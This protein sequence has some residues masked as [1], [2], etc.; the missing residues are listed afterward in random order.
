M[1]DDELEEGLRLVEVLGFGG[2]GDGLGEDFVNLA[3]VAEEDGFGALEFVGFNVVF[4]GLVVFNHLAGDRLGF[5]VFAAEIGVAEFE[6]VEG[7]VDEFGAGFGVFELVEQGD[8]VVELHALVLEA[9]HELRFQQIDLLAEDD[10][11]VFQNGFDERDDVEGVVFGLI[12][13]LGDG[14]EQVEAEGVVDGEVFGQRDI[15]GDFLRAAAFG[16]RDDVE[17]FRADEAAEEF[18]G[19]FFEELL[20]GGRLV[21]V[22]DD[23]FQRGAAVLGGAGEDVEQGV[24]IDGEAGDERFGRGG[25]EFGEGLFVPVHVAFFRGFAFFEGLLFVSSGFGGEAEVFDDVL[26]GL[27]DDVTGGVESTAAGATDDLAE[28]ANG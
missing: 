28:I 24:V 14:I 3:E 25:L 16:G 20:F 9:G 4:E 18:E 10:V 15:D 26:G 23:F 27:G 7:G 1:A 22:V 17:D 13:E 19:A 2:V 12:V 6:G 21:A 8:A 11:G 5:D